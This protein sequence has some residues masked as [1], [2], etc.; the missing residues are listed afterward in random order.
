M[1]K[2]FCWRQVEGS[3]SATIVYGSVEL[4]NFTKE[5]LAYLFIRLYLG[6]KVQTMDEEVVQYCLL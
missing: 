4:I 3:K 1:M 5:L 6:K 2:Q